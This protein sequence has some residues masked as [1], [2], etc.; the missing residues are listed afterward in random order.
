MAA[1]TSAGLV[2]FTKASSKFSSASKNGKVEA[3]A[4][5]KSPEA[6]MV[7]PAFS[8]TRPNPP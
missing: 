4:S 6:T 5:D 2:H 3:N 8:S 7:V 1:F